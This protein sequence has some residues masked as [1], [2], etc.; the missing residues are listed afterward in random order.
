MSVF[1]AIYSKLLADETFSPIVDGRIYHVHASQKVRAPYVIITPITSDPAQVHSG[2][3]EIKH[4]LFQ[5][6]CFAA[7]FSAAIEMR[8][9]LIAA[10]DGVALGN[11][12][13]PTLQD[14]RSSFEEAV[15]LHRADCD[16]LI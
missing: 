14:E 3:S 4:V 10:L 2:A 13:I 16:F 8:D 6:S 5:F 1:E 15:E 11:G 9:A 12:D 7:S